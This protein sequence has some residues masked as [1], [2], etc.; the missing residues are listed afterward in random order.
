MIRNVVFDMGQV[1]ARWDVDAILEKSGVCE[2]NRSLIKTE[3]FASP[4]WVLGDAGQRTDEE[5]LQAALENLPE[6][7]WEEARKVMD[8]FDEWSLDPIPETEALVKEVRA[9]GYHTYLLSNA[10]LRFP[11]FSGKIPAMKEMDGLFVS[12]FHKC[13]KPQPQI[14]EK[15]LKEFGLKAEECLFI[16][17]NPSNIAGAMM[18]G[19]QGVVFNGDIQR[20]RRQ[21]IKK[22]VAL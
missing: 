14:Y 12:A 15:F 21:L 20:L 5:I 22:G 4:E 10:S 19:M 11:K 17:D 8:H 1:L 2:P 9:A 18:A 13:M 7:S 16:D 6:S 3:L